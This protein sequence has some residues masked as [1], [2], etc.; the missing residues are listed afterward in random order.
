MRVAQANLALARLAMSEGKL[1]KAA[2]AFEQA[3]PTLET[4]AVWRSVLDIQRT[5]LSLRV[6]DTLGA[7]ARVNALHDRQIGQKL[8]QTVAFAR[9]LEMLAI[10]EARLGR[11]VDARSRIDA[12]A[13]LLS[14]RQAANHPFRARV[15][16]YAILLDLRNNSSDRAANL[17]ALAD[18]VASGR[19]DQITLVPALRALAKQLESGFDPSLSHSQFP[20]LF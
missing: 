18:R 7:F 5:E 12:A 19:T 3:A 9:T 16:A 13:S 1:T 8:S 14:T 15:D 6:A 4:S 2:E 10:T 20:L 17:R 11:I